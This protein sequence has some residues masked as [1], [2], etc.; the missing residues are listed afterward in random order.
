MV[1]DL[2]ALDRVHVRHVPPAFELIV[3]V[4]ALEQRRQLAVRARRYVD[5]YLRDRFGRGEARLALG[6]VGDRLVDSLL[7]LGI[8]RD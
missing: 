3:G 4:D 1:V 7:R 6:L 2:E 5:L 8:Q